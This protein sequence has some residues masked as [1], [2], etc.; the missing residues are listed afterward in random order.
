MSETQQAR[1]DAV[2]GQVDRGVMRHTPGPWAYSEAPKTGIATVACVE[3]WV[4]GPDYGSP[5]MAF[6]ENH[7]P[8]EADAR[9]IAATPDLLA[10]LQGLLAAVRR[11]TCDGSGPAQDAAAQALHKAV[12][13]A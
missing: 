13:A 6:Y 8:A 9:L 10:A 4:I 5:D 11:S 3:H 2:A 7:G 12:G 1:P